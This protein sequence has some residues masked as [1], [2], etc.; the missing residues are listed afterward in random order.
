MLNLLEIGLR[1]KGFSL[2]IKLKASPLD[3]GL[4]QVVHLLL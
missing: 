1:E 4:E 3:T 2:Y